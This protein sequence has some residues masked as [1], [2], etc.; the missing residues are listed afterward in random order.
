MVYTLSYQMYKCEHRLSAAEQRAADARAGDGA[1]AVREVR[2]RLG[3]ALR[4]RRRVGSAH[5]A[6][7]AVTGSGAASMRLLSSGR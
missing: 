6:A 3:R 7:G 2:L 5:P 1:G 4:P